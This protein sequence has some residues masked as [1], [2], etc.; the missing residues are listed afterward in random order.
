MLT[1]K[2]DMTFKQT[3]HVQLPTEKPDVFRTGSFTAEYKLI[4]NDEVRAMADE[5]LT[6]QQQLDRVLVSVDGV[7]PIEGDEKYSPAEQL[8]LVKE[9]TI[10]SLAALHAFNKACAKD[11]VGKTSKAP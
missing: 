11:I 10:T 4:S 6:V 5:K 8:Q 1:L 3:V 2:R 7:G 9:N